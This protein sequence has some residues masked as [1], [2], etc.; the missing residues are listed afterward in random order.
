M[1]ERTIRFEELEKE[2]TKEKAT[3]F[4]ELLK[5][6]VK[7][8][9][10]FQFCIMN[11][12]RFEYY[13]DNFELNDSDIP[14][15]FDVNLCLYDAMD[16]DEKFEKLT[17]K[18]AGK[19]VCVVLERKRKKVN[20]MDIYGDYLK[21]YTTAEIAENYEISKCNARKIKQRMKERCDKS[22]VS[23]KKLYNLLY[24]MVLLRWTK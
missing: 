11:P 18:Y 10:K 7:T 6:R 24:N 2:I 19:Y 1:S 22:M 16:D 12:E 21:G 13:F 17:K 8:K 23:P 3:I 15:N 14:K 9:N 5:E 4:K 20:N